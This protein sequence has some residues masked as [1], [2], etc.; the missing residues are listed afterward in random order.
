MHLPRPVWALLALLGWAGLVWAGIRWGVPAIIIAVVAGAFPDVALIG[1]FAEPGR[2]KP[3][4]VRFY[5]Y[6]HVL[7]GPLALVAV[8]LAVF[9]ITGAFEGGSFAVALV[10]FAWLVHIATDRAAG[11]GLR[12]ARGEI[13]P[14]GASSL[15]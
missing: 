6:L 3:E 7:P 4:R 5:N 11:F 15:G 12:D 1:A 9:V 10:G 14:V 8:G 13:L 2:L